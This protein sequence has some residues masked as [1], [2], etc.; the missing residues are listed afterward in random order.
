MARLTFEYDSSAI[1]VNDRPGA[2]LPAGVG[3]AICVSSNVKEAKSGNG[4]YVELNWLF[5]D[6]PLK[7]RNIT[8]RLNA[9][10]NSIVAQKMS[11]I[12][13]KL[14]QIALGLKDQQMYETSNYH[15]VPVQ[16]TVSVYQ[17]RDGKDQNGI[18]YS[19]VGSKAPDPRSTQNDEEPAPVS[20]GGAKKKPWEK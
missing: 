16:L 3:T 11:R 10:N 5:T 14:L 12:S 1:D 18:T 15:N 7:G 17:G 4:D 8:D 13:L 6:G 2:I 19:P 20:S 9:N